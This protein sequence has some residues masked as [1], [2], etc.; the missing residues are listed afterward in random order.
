MSSLSPE[1]IV[2][3][4]ILQLGSGDFAGKR[5]INKRMSFRKFEILNALLKNRFFNQ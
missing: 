1:P 5:K 2:F 4:T 3:D